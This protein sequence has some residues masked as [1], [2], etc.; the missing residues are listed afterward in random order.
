MFTVSY[1][2]LIIFFKILFFYSLE[3]QRGRDIEGEA[4]SLLWKTVW[5]FLKELKIELSYDP[6]SALLGIYPKDTDVVI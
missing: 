6:S 1:Y 3:T 5:R 2:F 4:G